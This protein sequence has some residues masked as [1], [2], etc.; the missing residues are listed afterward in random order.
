MRNINRLR[1]KIRFYWFKI[2][3]MKIS[4]GAQL[5]QGVEVVNPQNFT[6]GRSTLYK[7]VTVYL[8]KSGS[9]SMGDNSHIAPYGYC[10]IDNNIL[11]IGDY[12]AIGPSCTFVCHSNSIIGENRF[13]CQNYEDGDILIGNNVFIGAQCTILPGTIINDNVVIA[14]NSVV[15]GVLIGNTLYGGSPIREIRK[16]E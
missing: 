13:F 11:K 8:G 9:F 14:S 3:G 1:N 12:V 6:I 10:L 7:N 5:N 16:I 2:K 15:K 4:S